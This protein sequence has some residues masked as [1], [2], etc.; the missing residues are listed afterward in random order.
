L[1][2][3]RS[4]KCSSVSRLGEDFGRIFVV[5]REPRYKRLNMVTP[6]LAITIRN[7]TSTGAAFTTIA[8]ADLPVV[9][10]SPQRSNRRPRAER[11]KMWKISF[12]SGLTSLDG[13]AGAC[14][15]NKDSGD[16]LA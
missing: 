3:T 10:C 12:H 8:R 14:R 16:G 13:R 1:G 2:T 4:S 15:E 11:T 6:C 7:R 9:S 5:F